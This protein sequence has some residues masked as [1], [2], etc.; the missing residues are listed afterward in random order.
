PVAPTSPAPG[1]EAPPARRWCVTVPFAD[2]LG[3]WL[4]EREICFRF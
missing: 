3:T 2:W 4:R 1:A